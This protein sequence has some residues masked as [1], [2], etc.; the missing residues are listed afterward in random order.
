[1]Q[2]KSILLNDLKLTYF[3]IGSADKP[4]LLCIH[5]WLDNAASFFKMI[6]FLKEHFHLYLLELP[7]H[8]HSEHLGKSAH[9]HLLDSITWIEDFRRKLDLDKLNFCC[10]S[11]GGVLAG[12][13]SASFPENV[14]FLF[15]IEALGPISAPEDLGPESL[16]KYTKLYLSQKQKER[17]NHPSIESCIAARIRD[18]GVSRED[19]KLIVDRGVIEHNHQY[20]W[21]FDRKLQISSPLRMTEK[22][23]QNFL[24]AI[25][26]PYHLIVATDGIS[27]LRNVLKERSKAV[28]NLK[29]HN[30][31]G[32]HHVHME[33]PEELCQILADAFPF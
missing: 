16:R 13:Y 28:K 25:E 27:I 23:V 3:E 2:E 24:S 15:S 5:G 20:Q 14:N 33:K 12:L 29:I 26:C 6:P 22:Q 32:G 4:K 30:M 17:K 8:G 9:Y 10:H 7:G 21:T 1:M 19:A 31:T 18:G 11:L